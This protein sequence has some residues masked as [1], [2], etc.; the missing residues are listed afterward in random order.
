MA[1]GFCS[2]CLPSRRGFLGFAA[3]AGVAAT[4]LGGC[5][6]VG[7]NLAPGDDE[8]NRMGLQAWSQ[9]KTKEKVSTS[10]KGRSRVNGVARRVVDASGLGRSYNWEFALFDDP[11]INAFALPGGKIG[12]Y[13]GLL[14]LAT[15]DTELAA[16][17]GHE[18]THVQRR[19]AAQRIGAQRAGQLGVSLA[20]I[21]LAAGGVQQSDQIAGL[22]GA[23]VSYGVILPF[24]R[25]Q[26]YE[27]DEGGLV[28]MARAGYDPNGAVSLWQ[29]MAAANARNGRPLEFASTHPS[30][31]NRI[32]R[33]Q[34]RIPGVMPLYEQARRA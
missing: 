1:F 22:I 29:K 5:V 32:R 17:L 10:A 14:N 21:G 9:L 6:A 18:V 28:T 7:R 12:V 2:C 20:Q 27:A 16:V 26:E 15:K 19:H 33:L 11:Q 3:S 4:G 30:D 31:A 24:S 34:E 13:Q 25:D 8:L 23:G